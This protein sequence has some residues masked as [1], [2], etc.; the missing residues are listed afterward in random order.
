MVEIIQCDQIVIFAQIAGLQFFESEDFRSLTA[1]DSR[2][3]QIQNGCVVQQ[4]PFQLVIGD[5][6]LLVILERHETVLLDERVLDVQIE[7]TCRQGLPS[8]QLVG[9]QQGHIQI[10]DHLHRQPVVGVG[11]IETVRA[12]F[13]V[14]DGQV[15]LFPGIDQIDP[16]DFPADVQGAAVVQRH[17]QSVQHLF[18]TQLPKDRFGADVLQRRPTA[19]LVEHPSH[20][21]DRFAQLVAD[22]G[23][24]VGG[25]QNLIFVV[26]VDILQNSI[27]NLLDR[28]LAQISGVD[29]P[30]LQLVDDL[31][32]GF[33][34]KFART[35]SGQL[36][37][38]PFLELQAVLQEV[39]VRIFEI[40]LELRDRQI[41]VFPVELF[42]NRRRQL[43]RHILVPEAGENLLH[44]PFGLR[45][46]G[47]VRQNVFPQRRHR[48]IRRAL[49]AQQ[50]DQ[51][52]DV[53][54]FAA[55][56]GRRILRIGDVLV[57]DFDRDLQ[58]IGYARH[59]RRNLR[60]FLAVVRT[61]RIAEDELFRPRKESLVGHIRFS[62]HRFSSRRV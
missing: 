45:I 34:E 52:A 50:M 26:P 23:H 39:A 59:I 47:D 2:I 6:R 21:L 57:L 40:A 24:P 32:Q 42:G 55:E 5:D 13:V 1:F 36:V 20:L 56:E 18:A 37:F 12:R 53:L 31:F 49:V 33:M 9:I 7:S 10:G 27:G 46:L 44:D 30:A 48:L 4:Q 14:E 61:H 62:G 38:R 3:D 11:E 8:Q 35:G 41:Q 17:V 60:R 19:V 54:L 43:A 28:L 25:R 15:I 51:L 29:E 16:V 58:R 22:E